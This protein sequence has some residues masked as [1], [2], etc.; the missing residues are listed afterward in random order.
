MVKIAMLNWNIPRKRNEFR[1]N[2]HWNDFRVLF[3]VFTL[4]LLIAAFRFVAPFYSHTHTHPGTALKS[5]HFGCIF[6][7]FHSQDL[8]IYHIVPLIAFCY[9][10]LLNNKQL[11]TYWLALIHRYSF[12]V[13]VKKQC[14]RGSQDHRHNEQRKRQINK[15]KRCKKNEETNPY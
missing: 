3:F 9:Y 12:C 14:I 4:F 13:C 15:K 6:Y 8:M 11:C 5:I 2:Q 10:S 7:A 1:I